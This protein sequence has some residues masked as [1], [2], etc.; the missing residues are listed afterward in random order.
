V[1]YASSSSALA[2][3]STLNFNGTSLAVGDSPSA[4][5]GSRFYVY[6]NIPAST[7]LG[8]KIAGNANAYTQQAIRF[9]D[10]YFDAYAGYIGFTTNSLTFGSGTTEGLRLTSSSLYTASGINV[11]FGTSSPAQRLD[12]NGNAQI[13][14][15][16]AGTNRYLY[17]NGVAN[18]AGAIAF[19][20]SGSTKWLVGNGAASE[21]G[22][23]ELYEAT[24]GNTLVMTRAGNLGLGVTPVNAYTGLAYKTIE[25]Q[26][27]AFFAFD[28]TGAQVVMGLKA[29]AYYDSSA[30]AKYIGNGF[31]T[32]YQSTSGEHAWYTA[33]SN[34]SG[35]G[36]ACT[37]TQAMTLDA[38]GRLLIGMTSA[39]GIENVQSTGAI[40]AGN[41]YN[42]FAQG[43][44]TSNTCFALRT[45]SSSTASVVGSITFTGIAT[46]Y[47]TTSDQRL[48]ENIVDAPDFGSV[49]DS[50]QVRSF[51]WKTDSTHQRAGF[52]AQELVTVAPEAVHQPTDSDE[53]MAVDYSKLVPMLVKEIQSLRQRLSAANL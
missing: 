4:A 48:K 31:A 52:I 47:N 3:G 41:Q 33:P 6:G 16:T 46:L 26:K 51:D 38:S 44:T 23:F 13:G 17:I 9:Y 14:N 35:A 45:Y 11:G 29:N 24:S 7:Q 28:V 10:S 18:K 49:I 2:T 30:N 5:D 21:N 37:F 39:V 15:A 34:S 20:E 42:Y 1:V 32:Q 50:I 19:Q 22:N 12:V 25:V 53:M 27:A 36:A 8:I 40:S 43:N